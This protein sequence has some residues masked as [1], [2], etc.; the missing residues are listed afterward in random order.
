MLGHDP[1]VEHAD[2]RLA[3]LKLCRQHQQTR[4]GIHRQRAIILS[5]HDREQILEAF[6]TLSSSNAELSH[7]R[8]QG[9][10]QLRALTH[11]QVA[12]PV[13]HQPPLLLYGLDRDEP[14][15]RAPHRLADRLG[16]GGIVL[17]ALDVSLHIFGRHQPDFVAELPQLPCPMVRCGTRFHAHQ[18]RRQGLK[19]RD[20]LAAP[21]LL[22]DNHL[23]VG[24]DA[25]NL[26]DV[27]GEIQT[28]RANLHPDGPLI[29]IRLR[30]SRYGSSM[31]GAGVVHP[32]KS[33]REARL[34]RT[35]EVPQQADR[36][37]GTAA[38]GR[39]VPQCMARPRVARQTSKTTNVRC[40]I[41]VLGLVC[42][43]CCSGPA[44]VSAR[45]QD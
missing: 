29:V 21:Q 22:P 17:V 34:L 28:Y 42:G 14:H 13:L 20:Y 23:L 44:W 35:A 31:P 3:G 26:E 33:T 4:L 41:N 37:H 8:A 19:E 9:V 40:C 27:L 15:G 6:A 11:Q 39:S 25:V 45:I 12:Y 10:D 1:L 32:I 36:N 30:Q 24:V 16:I 43:A 5:C 38:N 7:M 2:Q 18:A